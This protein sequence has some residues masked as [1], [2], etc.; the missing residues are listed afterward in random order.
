MSVL[1]LADEQFGVGPVLGQGLER[2]A[3]PQQWARFERQLCAVGY[4]RRPVRLSGRTDAI[5]RDTGELRTVFSSEREPDG[6]L[7]T[8]CGNRREAV[9]PS[10]AEVYRGDA[11]QLVAAGMRGGKGVPETVAEHPLVFLTL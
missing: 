7:L 11:F 4:C 3:D 6:T 10:C 1:A 9:C 2:A 5:D 8:C